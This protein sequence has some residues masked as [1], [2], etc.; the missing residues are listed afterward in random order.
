MVPLDRLLLSLADQPAAKEGNAEYKALVKWVADFVTGR[1]SMTKVGEEMSEILARELGCP[2][3]TITGPTA[4][5]CYLNTLLKT[6]RNKYP[7]ARL[8]VYADDINVYIRYKGGCKASRD[9]AFAMMQ[10]ILSDI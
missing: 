9:K 2:Q 3:G 6:L 4:W 1:T 5:A 7:E 10:E 8:F